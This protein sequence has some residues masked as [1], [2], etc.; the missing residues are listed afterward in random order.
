VFR[1]YG[2][3]TGDPGYDETKFK[4]ETTCTC[5]PFGSYYPGPTEFL[6]ET[7]RGNWYV[8]ARFYIH[9]GSGPL[10][11]DYAKGYASS[12]EDAY[13]IP[14][15]TSLTMILLVTVVAAGV[16]MVFLRKKGVDAKGRLIPKLLFTN[17]E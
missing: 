13:E 7:D 11:G 5:P 12:T 17:H 3:F 15:F 2:P 14:W 1:W 4:L 9:T 10:E 16:F 8:G 6:E